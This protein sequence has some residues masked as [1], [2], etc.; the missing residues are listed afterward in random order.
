MPLYQSWWRRS[1]S[2]VRSAASG[3]RP[4]FLSSS[5]GRR[6][7]CPSRRSGRAAGPRAAARSRWRCEAVDAGLQRG[8]V[9]GG[10]VVE[11][12]LGIDQV[13]GRLGVADDEPDGR[14]PGRPRRCR[15]GSAGAPG[16]CAGRS[17]GRRRAPGSRRCRA[18]RCVPGPRSLSSLRPQ[19]QSR[20]RFSTGAQAWQLL[21]PSPLKTVAFPSQ[22]T[23]CSAS[24]PVRNAATPRRSTAGAYWCSTQREPE[25]GGQ[26]PR[27]HEADPH[28]DSSRSVEALRRCHR[29]DGLS[30]TWS[31]ES[32]SGFLPLFR[33]K[34]VINVPGQVKRFDD[35]RAVTRRA[36]A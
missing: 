30:I 2:G 23:P 15:R 31:E 5:D 27:T 12:L 25:L 8:R 11:V 9:P 10:V 6:G 14:Q 3:S 26:G 4:S 17:G 35:R 21:T 1:A 22:A 16:P 36:A 29:R 28:A 33:Q 20:S 18:V 34:H 32:F 19:R 7:R 13:G 24:E